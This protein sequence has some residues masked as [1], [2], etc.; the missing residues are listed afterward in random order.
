MDPKRLTAQ[1][2]GLRHDGSAGRLG[3]AGRYSL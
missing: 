3:I 1:V 2:E